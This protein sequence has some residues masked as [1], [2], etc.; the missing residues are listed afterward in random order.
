M[1]GYH[2]VSILLFCPRALKPPPA[3]RGGQAVR[4]PEF[5]ADTPNAF[6]SR[7]PQL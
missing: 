3:H 7:Q 5:A 2:D 4:F 1:T 6:A